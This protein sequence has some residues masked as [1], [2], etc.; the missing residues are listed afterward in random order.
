MIE[1]SSVECR[2][3]DEVYMRLALIA[4]S[5]STCVRNQVGAVLVLPSGDTI[6]G[7]NGTPEGMKSCL[8]GGCFR[9]ARPK[10][11]PPGQGY[12]IC[13]CVH[14]EQS[15]LLSAAR[16]GIAI[17]GATIYSTM[18]P[19]FGCSKELVQAGVNTI[20]YLDDWRHQNKEIHRIYEMME[21]P[22]TFRHIH[23]VSKDE[24]LISIEDTVSD[25]HGHG[26][27]EAVQLSLV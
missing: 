22:L 20:V 24:D 16:S 26:L 2:S 6:S 4:K 15:A 7:H 5:K 21:F 17:K 14:A 12:D 19:C 27:G 23:L 13:L 3:V 9:C 11:F 10:Q 1:E 18:R 8:E 25:E